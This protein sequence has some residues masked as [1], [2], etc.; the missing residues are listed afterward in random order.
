MSFFSDLVPMSPRDRQRKP[1]IEPYVM[2]GMID[3]QLPVGFVGDQVKLGGNLTSVNPDADAKTHLL[4][5]LLQTEALQLTLSDDVEISH[6]LTHPRP[7]TCEA[8]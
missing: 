8:G 2:D 4:I 3:V 7:C 5:S 1:V 6:N